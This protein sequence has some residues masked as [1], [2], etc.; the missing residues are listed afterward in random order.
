[1]NPDLNCDNIPVILMSWG[2]FYILHF[3]DY[4]INFSLY[5][6]GIMKCENNEKWKKKKQTPHR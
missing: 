1:M 2:S 6:E 3:T 5:L 4:Q